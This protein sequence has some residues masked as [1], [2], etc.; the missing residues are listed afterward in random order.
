[1]SRPSPL[2]AVAPLLAL[3]LCL[4]LIGH[5]AGPAVAATAAHD[6]AQPIF[7]ADAR[8][9]I[10]TVGNVTTTCDSGYTNANWSK[11]ESA[12]ACDGARNGST[13]VRNHS[14]EKI[15]PINNRLSMT[16]VDVDDDPATFASSTARLDMPAGA[17]VL[18]AGLHWNGAT[19][20]PTSPDYGSLYQAAPPSIGD[21]FEVLMRTPGSGA[22]RPFRA[23]PSDG[24][25]T[26]SWD[27]ASTDATVTYGGF[28]DVT[29]TV[30]AAGS[31]DYTVADVQ[32]CR[33]FGGCF[34]SWSLTVAYAQRDLPAR[35]LN[36][37]H[38]WTITN[39]NLN[40][41]NQAFTVNGITPPPSGPVNARIGVVQ[42]DG[43]RGLGPDSL[44]I[45]S[46]SSPWTTFKTADRP[47]NASEAP[48]WFNSTTSILGSRRPSTD[49]NPNYLANLDQDLALE[50][51]NTVVHNADRALSFRVH[52][53]GN[54]FLFSQV[55]HSAVEIH[56]PTVAIDKTVSPAGPVKAGA[57]TTWTLAVRNVGIDVV[58]HAVVADPL[59]AGLAL[60]PGTIAY[61]SGGPASLLGPKTEAAGDDEVDYDATTRTLRMRL[62][63]GAT[64]TTG[65]AM[66][67]P[68]AA[69]GSDRMTITFDAIVQAPGGQTIENVATAR[70]DGRRLDDPFGP[71]ITTDTGMA[72]IAVAVPPTTTTT[73]TA[74]PPPTTTT[75]PPTTTSPPRT[76][77]TAAAPATTALRAT[78]TSP[79]APHETTPPAPPAPAPPVTTGPLPRTGIALGGLLAAA[80]ALIAGGISFLRVRRRAHA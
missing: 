24:V 68:G 4:T 63:A 18:W 52:T 65:G 7:S 75:P 46:P 42:A 16:F 66:G 14:G 12:A 60:V 5:R 37:W 21:R 40:G 43:D 39:P 13:D 38:G 67:L 57:R 50:Q 70:G 19:K 25:T 20:A 6:F 61:A 41:G 64:A 29:D 8:G 73:T 35:N 49:A 77:T 22:Y 2:R 15:L 33:G 56:Q 1:M 36:V 17:V 47:L 32:S 3:A 78:T 76:T 34:G 44:E 26:D 28:V 30:K 53:E 58:D 62:G 69:D 51:T 27:S 9:D 79:P 55:V 72:S 11:A 59:P 31:G 74:P 48:D 71:I 80:T 54:E 45:S 10:A 23:T